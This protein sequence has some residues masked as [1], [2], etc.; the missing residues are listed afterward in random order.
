MTG[1][2]RA[3]H[4]GRT[5]SVWQIEI[6]DEQKRLVCTSRITMAVLDKPGVSADRR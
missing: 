2:C 3:V 4:V 5:T 6:R 1:E